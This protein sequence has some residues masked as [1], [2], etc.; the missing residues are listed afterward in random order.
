[1]C[2]AGLLLENLMLYIDIVVVPSVDLSLWRK[3]PG[4]AA[5]ALLVFG[6]IW[7]SR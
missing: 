4:L 5:L 3:I 2:F 1:V 6:L 7:D